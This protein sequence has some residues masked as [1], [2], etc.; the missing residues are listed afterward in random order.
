MRTKHGSMALILVQLFVIS[1]IVGALS[2]TVSATQN[3]ADIIT[4]NPDFAEVPAGEEVCFDRFDRAGDLEFEFV[5][6]EVLVKFRT[7]ISTGSTNGIVTTGIASVDKLN[8]RFEAKGIKKVFSN[9]YKLKLPNDADVFSVA[10]EYETDPNVE[11]AEP[12]G[13]YRTSV[14]PND[15]NY[16]QQWAHNII[17][18]E[19]AWN[20]TTGDPNVVV[21]IV[22]CGVDYNHP[23]L[24]ANI[25]TNI[26]EIPDNGIDD[27]ENGFIDDVRGWDFVDASGFVLFPYYPEEDYAEPDN[28][29]MDFLGHGSHCAGIV[30]A[31]GNNEIGIAGVTW[32]SKIMAVRSGFAVFGG[33]ILLQD[34]IVAGI[35]YATDNGADIISM[36]F[37]GTHRSQVDYDAIKY[38]YDNGVLLVAAAGNSME[39][40]KTYP[41]AYEEVVAVTATDQNDDPAWF[42]NFGGWVEVAA[43]GIDILSTTCPNASIGPYRLQYPY[44][45][46]GGTSMATPHVAGVAALIWSIFPNMTRNQVRYQLRRTAVDLLPECFDKYYGHGRINASGAVNQDRPDHDLVVWGWK[47]PFVSE[48]G[49]TVIVNTTVFNFGNDTEGIVYVKLLVN[50]AEVDCKK[51]TSLHTGEFATVTC[52]WTVPESE[53]KYNVTTYVVPAKR[54]NA[55]GNNAQSAYSWARYG[56]TLKVPDDFPTIEETIE[57]TNLE[58][59][60]EDATIW[61]ASGTY[62]EPSLIIQN[63]LTSLTLAGEDR[64]TTNISLEQAFPYGILVNA[65]NVTLKGFTIQNSYSAGIWLLGSN[66]TVGNNNLANNEYGIYSRRWHPDYYQNH[67]FRDNVV[68]KNGYGGI[69]LEWG[70][71][72]TI[73]NNTVSSNEHGVSIYGSSETLVSDNTITN[74]TDGILIRSSTDVVLDNNVLTGN[75]YDI[76]V[77]G[78]QLSHY[79]HDID[80]SNT[81]DGKPIYYLINKA[82]LVIDPFTFPNIGYLGI[83]NSTNITVKN[84]TLSNKYQGVLFAFIRDSEIQN[85][86]FSNNGYGIFLKS[87]NNTDI[88]SNTVTGNYYGVY[89]WS[90]INTILRNNLLSNNYFGVYLFS[91][92]DNS[93]SG[94]NVTDNN[95]GVF[96]NFS[97]NNSISGN[98]LKYNDYGIYLTSSSENAIHHNNF[99]NNTQQTY[100]SHSYNNTWNSAN[101][102]GNYWGDYNGTDTDGDGIGDTPYEIDENNQDNYPLMWKWFPGDLDGDG[103]VDP[104]D[105]STFRCAYGSEMGDP[106]Y[107]PIADLDYDCDVDDDDFAIFEQNYG[108][109]DP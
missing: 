30:A 32:N 22:D 109:T 65:D 71:G 14:V 89:I 96:L 56:K 15:A 68:S 91:S 94:N 64:S 43:P 18:S 41:A 38:A 100:I 101:L 6:G 87:S 36:S 105:F 44:D 8:R 73:I 52:S 74:S 11:Y 66:C 24:A 49:D 86:T 106:N 12:N 58:I 40:V 46:A 34:Q 85:V 67:T 5:P 16:T 88:S 90:S 60:G 107:N 62:N 20:V 103:D 95:N 33:G 23:D 17:E 3:E 4:S 35:R 99:I 1:A 84:L 104:F 13:I 108:K 75:T 102:V 39:Q 98:A 51:T 27:D 2:T 19:F 63:M 93:V 83:V 76:Y 61:V 25:W 47:L 26:D 50:G 53:E 45:Y 81:V 57:T 48:P 59:Y 21:A 69:I 7:G 77:S 54:E 78:S 55:I 37:G 29:P 42:T 31:V 10:K 80:T 79:I 92:S 72:D 28:D 97:S 70:D 9:V 82:N